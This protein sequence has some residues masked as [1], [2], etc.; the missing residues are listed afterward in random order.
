M[1]VVGLEGPRPSIII[2]G[3]NPWSEVEQHPKSEEPGDSVHHTRGGKVVVT[4]VD[5]QPTVPAPTP[6]G[7]KDPDE[8]TEK[9]GEHQIRRYTD[10]LN[11]GARH[12]RS[13][14]PRE[15]EE[16]RPEDSQDMVADVRTHELAPW[17]GQCALSAVESIADIR[18]EPS[19][20]APVG[21]PTGVVERRGDD[22]DGH[23]VLDRRRHDVLTSAD[24]GFVTHEAH[25]EEPHEDHGD[26][27]VILN[28]KII[29]HHR[30]NTSSPGLVTGMDMVV[31]PP[32]AC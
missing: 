2:E 31:S 12:D 3:A 27:V 28:E 16:C 20:H 5:Y 30:A 17:V 9:H 15:Q 32:I 14:G 6:G 24:S 21:P 22:R 7:T 18:D 13:C 4:E 19:W 1:E 25:M 11:G 29:A 23:D 8:R 10:A 26:E